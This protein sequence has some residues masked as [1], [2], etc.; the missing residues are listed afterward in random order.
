MKNTVFKGDNYKYFK[1][2]NDYQGLVNKF[3]GS[4]FAPSWMHAMGEI[5]TLG[6]DTTDW[7]DPKAAYKSWSSQ[8]NKRKNP[9]QYARMRN[10]FKYVNHNMPYIEMFGKPWVNNIAQGKGMLGKII[11]PL[12]KRF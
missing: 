12:M 7:T 8:I 1:A 2:L 10:F 3:R 5:P 6:F 4:P 11:P 9:L